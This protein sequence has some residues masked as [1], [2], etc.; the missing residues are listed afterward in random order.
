MFGDLLVYT[1]GK[2]HGSDE[3][4]KLGSTDGKLIVTIHENTY[5]SIIELNVG[6]C[7]SSLDISFDCSNDAN[8]EGLFL[9]DSLKSTDGKVLGSDEGI[10]LRSTYGKVFGTILVN[11]DRITLRIDIGT[12]LGSL[13]VYFDGFNDVKLEVLFLGD[14]VGYIDG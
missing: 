11:V 8:I 12:D 2:L 13:D 10:K 5:R 1:D 4:I 9:G 7:I 6:K 3:G 14:S